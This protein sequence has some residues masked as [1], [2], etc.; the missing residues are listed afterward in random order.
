MHA[1]SARDVLGRVRRVVV[2]VGSA[3]LAPDGA[4]SPAAFARLAGGI[5][6]AM[7]NNIDVVVVSSGAVASGFR[8]L[9]LQTPPKQ[10]SKKQAAAAVGQHRLMASWA[11]AFEP[12]G[13][14]VAQV[15]YT[16]EDLD[17]RPRFLNARRTLGE[18]L[19]AGI[20]P[21]VNENDSVSFAEI[22]LGD[23]D[24]LSALT[25]GLV[26]AGLLLILSSVPGLLSNGVDAEKS[27]G[28]AVKKGEVVPTVRDLSDGL[29]HVRAEKTGVGTGGMETKLAAAATAAGWGIPTVIASGAVDLVLP[30]VL[31]GERI[32]TMFA[33]AMRAR[34]SRKRWIESSARPRGTI[35][36]DA[37]CKAAI[38][39]RGASLLPSGVV[40]VDGK[41]ARSTAV[42]IA[43]EAGAVFARGIAAYASDEIE[44]IRGKKATQIAATLGYAYCDEVVHRDDLVVVAER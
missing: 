24:R 29:R 12:H 34:T 22:K 37:G 2:K 11:A 26:D 14:G 27:G 5:A 28:T 32:G 1:D 15:L 16:A 43:D 41:F 4:P 36:V 3:V 10:I 30:R 19:D 8:A 42:Q 20:V 44:K 17:A 33:P 6:A 35:R 39:K 23:N 21:I 13:I 40:A 25:A 18:L 31:A 38:T 7:S 9:G